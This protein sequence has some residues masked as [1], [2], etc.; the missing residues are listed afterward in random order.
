MIALT[1]F[2]GFFKISKQQGTNYDYFLTDDFQ[3]RQIKRIL[4]KTLGQLFIENRQADRFVAIEKEVKSILIAYTWHEMIKLQAFSM[5][6]SGENKAELEAASTSRLA[7]I[8][9]VNEYI[10]RNI[11]LIREIIEDS[12][13]YPEFDLSEFKINYLSLF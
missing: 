4:G 1:D 11:E 3:H 13:T 7:Q 8:V 6:A 10:G 2:T 5:T 12:S 9:K